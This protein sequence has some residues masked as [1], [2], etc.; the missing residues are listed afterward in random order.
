MA[1]RAISASKDLLRRLEVGVGDVV[2]VELVEDHQE[3][4][5]AEPPEL[6]AALAEHPAAKAAYEQLPTATALSTRDGSRRGRSLRPV[7]IG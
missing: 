5:V 3:R 7:L 2:E 1:V 6:T 4:V